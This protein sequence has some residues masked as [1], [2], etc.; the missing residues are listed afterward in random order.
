ME[1]KKWKSLQGWVQQEVVKSKKQLIRENRQ[2]VIDIIVNYPIKNEFIREYSNLLFQQY[3]EENE[4]QEYRQIV[5]NVKR[6]IK[7][8]IMNQKEKMSIEDEHFDKM[9]INSEQL[10]RVNH[11]LMS[12]SSKLS[13]QQIQEVIN[14]S[15]IQLLIH[16]LMN[17]QKKSE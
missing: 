4:H 6:V 11:F 10:I 7:N 5:N 13:S 9:Q 2:L 14:L 16:Y 8:Y 1:D 17:I 15:F 3:S 12:L